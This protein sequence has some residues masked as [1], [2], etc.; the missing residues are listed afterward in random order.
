MDGGTA[1]DWLEQSATGVRIAVR[2]APK[3]G[4]NAIDGASSG[5]LKIRVTA[6]PE[7][8]KANA[9]VCRIVAKRLGIGKTGVSVFRGQS[10]RDKV[11]EVSGMST[12]EVADALAP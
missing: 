2:V 1:P 12:G 6:A 7:D 5:R 8:G 11:L 4:A 9:A 10:H 3:A